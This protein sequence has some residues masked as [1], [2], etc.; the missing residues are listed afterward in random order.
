MADVDDLAAKRLQHV[1]HVG[2]VFG[3][4]AEALFF[5]AGFV[6]G[7]ACFAVGLRVFDRDAQGGVFVGH[8]TTRGA[9]QFGVF[10]F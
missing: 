5:E 10:W 1:L 8:F 4:F 7:A 9:D 2:T 3:R 6:F